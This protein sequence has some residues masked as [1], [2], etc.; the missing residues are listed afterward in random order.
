KVEARLSEAGLSIDQLNLTT[1]AELFIRSAEHVQGDERDIVLLSLTY[2]RDANG[3]LSANFGS[4]NQPGGDKRF[5]VVITRAKYRTD[6]FAS[7][8]AA[9]MSPAK[10]PGV[11][12]L[13][14]YLRLAELGFP[15]LE[16]KFP[17]SELT[18]A[19]R[20]NSF[21]AELYNDVM[22]IRDERGIHIGAIY[23]TGAKH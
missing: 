3:K 14:Y 2:G 23:T 8:R 1:D 11:E 20:L 6:V 17:L 18:R 13:K 4:L 21:E 12:V 16:P 7:F 22:C 15:A 9:Q 10:T 5:N 19:L